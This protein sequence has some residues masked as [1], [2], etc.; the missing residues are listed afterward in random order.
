MTVKPLNLF[1]T[2]T[3]DESYDANSPK[4]T[5]DIVSSVTTIYRQF[6]DNRA[7]V[8]LSWIDAWAKYLNT[9]ESREYSRSQIMREVGNV[10]SDWRHKLS[11]GKTFEAVET[12]VSYLMQSL[13]PSRQWLNVEAHD[14]GYELL[15]RVVKYFLQQKL[16]DWKFLVEMEAYLRQMAIT[17]NSV[18][19]MPWE[20]EL[21]IHFETLDIFDCYYNPREIHSDK[22]PFVRRVTQTRADIIEKMQS[23]YY[24]LK[25]GTHDVMTMAPF[26]R[27]FGM[28]HEIEYDNHGQLIRQFNGIAITTCAL[29]DKMPVLEYWGDIQL[30]GIII[31]DAVATVCCGHLLRLV[32]NPYKCGRP[33]VFGT[34]IPVVRQVYGLSAIQSSSGMIHAL[35]VTLNQMMDGVELAVNP[36]Y[37]MEPDANLRPQ[38][39]RL[40]PGAILPVDRHGALAPVM[41]PQNNFGLSFQNIQ[42]L[43]STTNR[44]IGIGPLVGSAPMRSGERVTAR[45]VEAAQDAGGNRLFLVFTHIKNTALDE[46]LVKLLS[47]TQ[48]FTDVDEVVPVQQGDITTYYDVGTRELQFKYKIAARGAEFIIEQEDRVN[49]MLQLLGIVQS[50]PPEKA[51]AINMDALLADIISVLMHEDPDRYLVPK[52][53]PGQEQLEPSPMAAAELGIQ[54]SMMADGG[55]AM[56]QQALGIDIPGGVNNGNLGINPSPAGVEPPAY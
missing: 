21:G 26:N 3:Y 41:P 13:F 53:T 40:E 36:M 6:K 31:R 49:R 45:E 16:V 29:T 34:F 44:N 11:S 1:K 17:G 12:V 52:E 54:E 27:T 2:L 4:F 20:D 24:T 46:I 42:F 48:Q 15:A 14:Y 25:G 5:E 35:D 37:T 32:P 38:D 9:P 47:I 50:L 30:P 23:K 56:L 18:L 33:F 7:S 28:A 39:I 8:E 22:S 43:E 10:K 51:A 19:A 55:Q